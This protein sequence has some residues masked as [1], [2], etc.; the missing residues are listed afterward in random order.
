[1]SPHVG[2]EQ[3]N[4]GRRTPFTRSTQQEQEEQEE[5]KSFLLGLTSQKTQGAGNRGQKAK[6]LTSQKKQEERKSLPGWQGGPIGPPCAQEAGSVRHSNAVAAL[7]T[8]V[9]PLPDP[10]SWE[11]RA[12]CKDL[13]PVLF[14][15]VEDEPDHQRRFR[16]S[17]A[18]TICAGCPVA[19]ECLEE[20]LKRGEQ[21]GIWGGLTTRERR[22]LGRYR[23]HRN[24]PRT[25]CKRGHELTEDNVYLHGSKRFCRV[26]HNER[27]NGR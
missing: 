17:R 26:C 27:V 19:E 7:G 21:F 22:K 23:E 5:S 20:A 16:V 12:A 2:R 24:K 6:P 11:D 13:D 4:A 14:F 18:K 15:G 10:E 9:K 8:P 3:L 1:M 25:H